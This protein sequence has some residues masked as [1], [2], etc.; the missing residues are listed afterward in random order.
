MGFKW[1][2]I[3][4]QLDY[5]SSSALSAKVLILEKIADENITAMKAVYLNDYHTCKLASNVDDNQGTVIG[6]ALNSGLIGVTINILSFGIIDD[7][8]FTFGLNE[9]VF[10]GTNGDLITTQ[11]LTGVLTEIGYGLGAGSIYVKI[12]SPKIL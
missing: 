12:I 11:P 2:P 10:L 9:P 6:I 7:P 1:N 4:S 8:F 3:T 5:F